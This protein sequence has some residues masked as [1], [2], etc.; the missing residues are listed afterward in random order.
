MRRCEMK[1]L[2]GPEQRT[3]MTGKKLK[4]IEKQGSYRT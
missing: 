4:T 1:S 2:I 3:G